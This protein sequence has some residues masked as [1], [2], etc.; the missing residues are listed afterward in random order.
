MVVIVGEKHHLDYKRS[1]IEN[2]IPALTKKY[3]PRP[4]DRAGGGASTLISQAKREIDVPKRKPRP[5]AEGG[6]IDKATGK[7]VF[8]PTGE[9]FVSKRTGETITKTE[10][11]K[12]LL[13]FDSAHRLSSGTLI[14]KI[15]A[16][17]SDRMRSLANEARKELVHTKS[18]PYSPSAKAAYEP[19]VK[20]LNHK[21]NVA[22]QNSPR[23]RQAQLVANAIIN[24]KKA[25]NPNMDA[26]DLKKVKAK[27]LADARI[28]TGADKERVT[29]TP[30]EWDAIQAGAISNHHLEQILAHANLDEVKKLATPRT[31][32]VMTE[33]M[34][35]RAKSMLVSG[36]TQ[37][38]VAAQLGVP[39]STLKSDIAK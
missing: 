23:E 21:L 6:P 3:Q 18:T 29:I 2:G 24:S 16:D 15:Y 19:Q 38:E 34:H 33:V 35:A 12:Q 30:D 37:A 28:R 31:N 8:V 5:A 14:E 13:E 4:D 25:A 7:R 22:L 32:P 10:K 27:A 39:L 26:A 17:H 36:F 9:T 1:A 11:A 20:S